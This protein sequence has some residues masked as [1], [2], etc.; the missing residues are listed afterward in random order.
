MTNKIRVGKYGENYA[1]YHNGRLIK[2]SKQKRALKM[3]AQLLQDN[4]ITVR[5]VKEMKRINPYDVYQLFRDAYSIKTKD[6]QEVK[7]QI[8]AKMMADLSIEPNPQPDNPLKKNYL[9][10]TKAG[11]LCGQQKYQIAGKD[12]KA[13]K[14]SVKKEWLEDMLEAFYQGKMSL[15]DIKRSQN[16]E[17]LNGRNS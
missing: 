12:H 3:L 17:R 14:T 16:K 1:L 2:R 7:K 15:E 8:N 5:Q 10:I 11:M 6:M 13:I 4:K 9:R